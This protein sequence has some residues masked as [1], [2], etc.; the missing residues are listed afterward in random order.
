ML[1]SLRAK[2]QFVNVVNNIAQIIAALNLVFDLANLI[3]NGIG[4]GG[5]LFETLQVG[6]E[7]R[8]DKLCQVIANPNLVMV[9]LA[10]LA[11]GGQPTFPIGSLCR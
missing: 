6:K 1:F 8:I 10:V 2:T 3:F 7:L 9:K 11:L 5:F 4:A